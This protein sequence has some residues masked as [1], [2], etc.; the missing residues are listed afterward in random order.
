MKRAA[1]SR[2]RIDGKVSK[3]ADMVVDRGTR[4]A[5]DAMARE[6]SE[7]SSAHSTTSTEEG[8]WIGDVT[9]PC[10][11]RRLTTEAG[12]QSGA[13]LPV[14]QQSDAMLSFLRDHR[15]LGVCAPPGSGKTMVL[16]ELLVRLS[17]E[18]KGSVVL[19]VPTRFAAQK[20]LESFTSFRNWW[21]NRIH[22]RTGADKQDRFESHHLRNTVEVANLRVG[23]HD[24]EVLQFCSGRVCVPAFEAW[25][26]QDCAASDDRDGKDSCEHGAHE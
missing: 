26:Q 11:H 22:L 4:S 17:E 14:E 12:V 18:Y 9:V 23:G 16:P 5:S 25:S 21:R 6:S 15:L 8:M 13:G 7:S 1:S 10:Y 20:I 19:V 24:S 3:P 2:G